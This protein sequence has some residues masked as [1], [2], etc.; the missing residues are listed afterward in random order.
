MAKR[1]DLTKAAQDAT[2]AMFGI[3]AGVPEV[4]AAESTGQT[5]KSKKT[6]KTKTAPLDGDTTQDAPEAT[7]KPRRGRPR[8][9]M[10]SSKAKP[11]TAI[12]AITKE[13]EKAKKEGRLVTVQVTEIKQ[14][15]PQPVTVHVEMKEPETKPQKAVATKVVFTDKVP[16]QPTSKTVEGSKA[17]K[18]RTKSNGDYIRLDMVKDGTNLKDYVNTMARVQGVSMTA[19]I[20]ELILK[21]KKKNEGKTFTLTP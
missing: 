16:T 4:E 7:Q 11:G 5:E 20:Q 3:S 13:R 14:P 6:K 2:R 21:D 9:N 17:K 18:N 15:E 12:G 1:K 19:Y 8:K 10:E